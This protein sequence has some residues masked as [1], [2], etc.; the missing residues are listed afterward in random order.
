MNE[1]PNAPRAYDPDDEDR[2]RRWVADQLARCFRADA[3]VEISSR[4]IL[5]SPDA[6]G[7]RVTVSNAGALSTEPT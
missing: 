4:L 5:R 1:P 6:G 3:D 7:H 2:F